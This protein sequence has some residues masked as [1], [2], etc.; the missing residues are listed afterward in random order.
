[1]LK[2]CETCGI[3]D[4]KTSVCRL[5][6]QV[7]TN[8]D[9]CSKHKTRVETCD[10]CHMPTL[11]PFFVRDGENWHIYCA[12]CVKLL[13]T[14]AFCKRVEICAFETDPS[15]IPKM[16]Q[17]QVRQ[18]PMVSITTV[19]NPERVRITCE[20]GCDCFNS[21]FG[22]MREFHYCERMDYIYDEQRSGASES[23]EIHSEVHE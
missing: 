6:G 19:M 7:M 22:C 1:M 8:R 2:Y 21:E 14:C 4:P 10:Y 15:P 3:L 18:G 20:K 17:Q 13:S 11:E 16:V 12:K 9:Y 23:S 5:S